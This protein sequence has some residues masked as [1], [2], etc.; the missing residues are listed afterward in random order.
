[1]HLGLSANQTQEFEARIRKMVTKNI[2]VL[3]Y[4]LPQSIHPKSAMYGAIGGIEEL[5]FMGEDF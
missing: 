2:G 5:D 4:H 3:Y 1:M